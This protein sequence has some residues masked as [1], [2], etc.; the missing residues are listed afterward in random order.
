[1]RSPSHHPSHMLLSPSHSLAHPEQLQIGRG[2]RW[3]S[4]LICLL[5]P[6]AGFLTPIG[7]NGS[8]LAACGLDPDPLCYP[9]RGGRL[10]QGY[11]PR[12]IANRAELSPS[13]PILP[14]KM[15]AMTFL[16]IP[17]LNLRNFHDTLNRSKMVLLLLDHL[18]PL[19]AQVF[20]IFGHFLS[21]GG[22]VVAG[23]PR[24]FGVHIFTILL[25]SFTSGP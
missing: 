8:Q 6:S 1:M 9:G 13:L 11:K 10:S 19:L 12:S 20:I 21:Q 4:S 25:G 2:G 16:Q 24:R 3:Q 14:S 18:I 7:R 17:V 22:V 5:R 23:A 15:E